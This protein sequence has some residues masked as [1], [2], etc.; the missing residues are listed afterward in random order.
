[1][2]TVS[3]P[4][5]NTRSFCAQTDDPDPRR[6][7]SARDGPRAGARAGEDGDEAE[8][9]DIAATEAYIAADYAL[10]R[11][12]R[13]NMLTGEA[14]LEELRNKISTECPMAAAASPE[15]E[16]AEH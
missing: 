9:S 3:R 7:P 10:V 16:A 15:N 12:A 4:D 2:S 11:T 5:N 6:Q 14:A 1:M 13:T 8:K